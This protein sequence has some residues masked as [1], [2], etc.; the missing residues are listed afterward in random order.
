MDGCSCLH[1]EPNIEC[2]EMDGRA[3][4]VN[5]FGLYWQKRW[6]VKAHWGALAVTVAAGMLVLIEANYKHM[7]NVCVVLL[8]NRP[9][10]RCAACFSTS[11]F[12]YLWTAAATPSSALACLLSV[13]LPS[14]LSAF[15]KHLLNRNAR[16][17]VILLQIWWKTL[18]S[19][20]SC[21]SSHT[22]PSKITIRGLNIA[23]F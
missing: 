6:V 7:R 10:N 15:I 18:Y 4:L 23:F 11:H 1:S 20:W 21:W 22:F 19:D 12:D 5:R 9:A 2:R 14:L 16:K 17:W 3:Q 8:N 13:S